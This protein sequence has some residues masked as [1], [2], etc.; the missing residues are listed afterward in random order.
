MCCSRKGNFNYFLRSN[1]VSSTGSS[2]N[3]FFY[4]K[5]SRETEKKEIDTLFGVLAPGLSRPS[6]VNF[7]IAFVIAF[8]NE[9]TTLHREN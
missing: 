9:N 7:A 6:P 1:N 4:V 3:R 5:T 2:I 8:K